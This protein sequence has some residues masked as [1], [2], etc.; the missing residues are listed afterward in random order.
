MY[1]L[2]VAGMVRTLLCMMS[3]PPSLHPRHPGFPFSRCP[4]MAFSFCCTCPFNCRSVLQIEGQRIGLSHADMVDALPEYIVIEC[5]D[6]QDLCRDPFQLAFFKA[7]ALEMLLRVRASPAD[8]QAAICQLLNV[9]PV[10]RA[11]RLADDARRERRVPGIGTACH[12]PLHPGPL[13]ILM[14]LGPAV[15]P[16]RRYPV[17]CDDPAVL[18]VELH[19]L[20]G[21][22]D[23]LI[24]LFE[25]D[26]LIKGI[27]TEH[28][29]RFLFDDLLWDAPIG[30][31]VPAFPLA[32]KAVPELLVAP[33][34]PQVMAIAPAA[35]AAF[36]FPGKAAGIER[37]VRKRPQFPAPCHL[38]LHIV[39]GGLVDDGLVGI[40]HVILRQF[41]FIL[42]PVL[43]DGVLD[44]FLL[45]EHVACVVDVRQDVLDIGIHPAAAL[46]CR[47]ALGGEL[48]LCLQAGFPVEEVLEDAPDDGRFLRDDDELVPFPA[49]SVKIEPAVRDA[50][51]EAFL[52]VPFD[53]L[54]DG[55]AFLLR[56]GCQDGQHELA[57]VA[58]CADVFLLEPHLDAY[59]LQMPDGLEKVHGVPG[60]PLDSFRQDKVYLAIFGIGQ[61]A[62]EG[63]TFCRPRAGN[64]VIGI[65]A[66]IIP[67]RILLDEAAVVADLRR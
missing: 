11:T 61:H 3:F 1:R 51:L 16:S 55:P 8:T 27:Q 47:D 67:F 5:R 62:V 66:R 42:L 33:V 41:A 9:V 37:L 19:H 64:A 44:I 18:Q 45:Q 17:P 12:V 15:L 54:A 63:V 6:A 36:D 50:L 28:C 24:D 38:L 53:V 4:G 7:G 13:L 2:I 22:D 31:T 25:E 26:L 40:L 58:E 23:D 30:A 59:L 39:E 35:D 52:Y 43:G 32:G 14:L 56:K 20:V 29:G 46:P 10:S 34:R 60:K 57:V 65:Y 48:A 21:R 49:V